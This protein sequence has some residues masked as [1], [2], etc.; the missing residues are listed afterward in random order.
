[1]AGKPLNLSAI[2]LSIRPAKNNPG[3]S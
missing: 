2:I 3:Y 1:M